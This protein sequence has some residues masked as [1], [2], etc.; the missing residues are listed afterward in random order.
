MGRSGTDVARFFETH[1][2]HAGVIR[3]FGRDASDGPGGPGRPD[4]HAELTAGR[5]SQDDLGPA[6]VTC[7]EVL[8]ALWGLIQ[9]KLVGDQE[10]GLGPAH[11]HQVARVP[12]V[13]PDR[14]LAGSHPLALEPEQAVVERDLAVL[15]QFVG[16]ARILRHV[17]ADD[18]DRSGEA[19]R[20]DQVVQ[21]GVRV[22][23]GSGLAFPSTP[24][25]GDATA[26][27]Y[28]DPPS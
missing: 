22:L 13:G 14:A 15:G 2:A 28:D 3:V 17:H 12:V 7:V 8:V 27:A 19:D 4:Q 1:A 5:G 26:V 23:C 21:R 11:V 24:S 6:L 10:R 16:P 25:S 9:R 18:A 20:L